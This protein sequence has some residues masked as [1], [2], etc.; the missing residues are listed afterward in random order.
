MGVAT[1][2]DVL[3]DARRDNRHAEGH[4]DDRSPLDDVLLT[5][6]VAIAGAAGA[7]QGGEADNGSDRDR[8]HERRM[9]QAGDAW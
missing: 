3:D 8:N 1:S 6:G 9:A 2:A 7:E 5:F 4:Q